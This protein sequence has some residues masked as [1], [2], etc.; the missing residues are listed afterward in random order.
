M[1]KNVRLANYIKPQR[2]RLMIKP[3]LNGFTFEGEETIY[4]N[5]E[6]SVR[7]ISLHAKELE[8]SDIKFQISNFKFQAKTITYNQKEETATFT[9]AKLLPKGK[10]E[11]SLSF[12][13]ILNDKM[14]GFYRSKYT[15]QGKDRYIATT[16]FE[17]TDARRAFPCFD[18]PAAKAVFD[19]TLMTPKGLTAISNTLPVNEPSSGPTGHLLPKG[20]G[21]NEG[22]LEHESGYNLVKFAAT[23]KMSTYLVAFIVGEFEYIEGYAKA[24]EKNNPSPAL[25]S[26][27]EGTLVRVFVTPGKKHQAKFALDTAIKILE[28]YN[29]YFDIPYPLPVLDLIA[30][31]D[32]SHGAME[33]WGAVTY[34]EA[35]LLVD[36][37]HSSAAN[38]QWV[39]L[40]I[41]HELA[42]QWFGNLV[43]MEWWTHL[44][45][46]E[47]FASYI[48]YLAVNQVFPKWDIWTQFAAHDLNPALDLD[49]LKNTHPIE[50]Q[51]YHPDEIGEIFDEISYSKGASV[52]RMLAGYLG[53]KDFRNG[54]RYY[55]KKHSYKN[56]STVH[57][58]QAFEKISKKPVRKLMQNWTGKAGYPVVK[59]V[60]KPK[61]LEFKQSRFF[62]SPI[63]KSQINDKTIWQI[64]IS[65]RGLKNNQDYKVLLKA[66]KFNSLYYDTFLP[67]KINSGETGFFRTDYPAQMLV[68]LR[69]PIANKK[70]S[71]L[72]RLGIIR[73]AFA[74]SQSG[75]F[76]TAQALELA[77]AYKD[78]TDYTVWLQLASGLS[79]LTS[80]LF[81]Q[82]YYPLFEKFARMIFSKIGQKLDW[83]PKKGEGHTTAL[84]RSLALSQLAGFNDTKILSE[85]LNI[86][87]KAFN[88]NQ[89]IPAD[90][91]GVV[92]YVAAQTGGV[93]TYDYFIS[94]YKTES[95]SEER[96]R[97]GRAL[98]QF[99]N[100]ALLKKTLKFALSEH[101]RLQD[102]P[103]IFM[104]VWSNPLGRR[105]AWKF[106]K[107]NWK[108]LL[109]RYPA[110]GHMLNR[111]I[112]SAGN[113]VTA[114]DAQDVRQF[115]KKHPAPGAERSVAQV[116]EQISCFDAW[117]KRDGKHIEHWLK[118][119]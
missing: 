34:R 55:L 76:P 46:N 81:E 107:D 61:G 65:I 8:V 20:E 113:L 27:G 74:L 18:E 72:D 66:E 21:D 35:A 97:I 19:I 37:E 108:T 85:G 44:W 94:K 11:L 119:N 12:K 118:Q 24:G 79:D 43:T 88:R 84:L 86:F 114:A 69:E 47:G 101:V 105:I 7:E 14:R 41:A 89:S 92:Y 59:I 51:V 112:K 45:L 103:S 17:A 42:H 28:F 63:S 102:S 48:E 10:G 77:L 64:P 32:F 83:R 60:Q 39:A 78:E 49:S 25:P 3:D 109:T 30:I 82:K 36:N 33:N 9:F 52:I 23:P 2:Y 58:W 38:K 87:K 67:L 53:E 16:Q 115:F 106:T 99:K 5:L 70:L 93:D 6:K 50:I 95:L 116:I 1:K 111:F 80:L 22:L 31:P 4:L 71:A 98:G 100:P 91:R 26:K 96:N 56:A 110:S 15:H 29:K 57:L 104:S 75:D 54:L 90:I 117:Q 62:S 13:G 68:A 40:V 73:D